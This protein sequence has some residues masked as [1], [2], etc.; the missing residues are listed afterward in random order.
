MS[1][2]HDWAG[3]AVL[4]LDPEE[5][6]EVAR[7]G[8]W[9]FEGELVLSVLEVYCRKCRKPHAICAGTPCSLG[10]QHVG[11]PR[12]PPDEEHIPLPW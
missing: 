5:A 6:A 12:R 4:R 7:K 2:T 10:P 1:R 3:A 9:R 8:R 11:G